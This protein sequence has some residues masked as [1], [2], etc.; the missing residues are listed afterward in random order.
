MGNQ[1]VRDLLKR[2]KENPDSRLKSLDLYGNE[3]TNEIA[4]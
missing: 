3:L 1:I 4:E 2:I